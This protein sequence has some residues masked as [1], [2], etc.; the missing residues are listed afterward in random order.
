MHLYAKWMFDVEVGIDSGS[1]LEGRW[2]H[3]N[4][5]Q[6]EEL[7]NVRMYVEIINK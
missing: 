1:G 2:L 5:F 7:L 6:L 4:R 3:I